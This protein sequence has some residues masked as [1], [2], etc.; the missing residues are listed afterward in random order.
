MPHDK[1]SS[2]CLSSSYKIYEILLTKILLTPQHSSWWSRGENAG[3]SHVKMCL[4]FTV[5][6]LTRAMP[7]QGIVLTHALLSVSLR[8]LQ[9]AGNTLSLSPSLTVNLPVVFLKLK[10]SVCAANPFSNGPL[11]GCHDLHLGLQVCDSPL[12]LLHSVWYWLLCLILDENRIST[13]S[14]C[15]HS[16]RQAGETQPWLLCTVQHSHAS[17]PQTTTSVC[18]AKTISSRI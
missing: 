17:C 1:S 9:Q 6:L 15:L 12:Q 11:E 13:G 10:Y 16:G 4:C 2:T 3:T 14:I 8:S 5:V 7:A 18:L